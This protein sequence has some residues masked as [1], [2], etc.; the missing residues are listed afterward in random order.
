[1]EIDTSGPQSRPER[2]Y[3]TLLL[4]ETLERAGNRFILFRAFPLS[5]GN[6]C[7]EC[8]LVVYIGN[9]VTNLVLNPGFY[10]LITLER[11]EPMGSPLS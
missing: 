5:T 4:A 6:R 11:A 10:Q 9:G 1:M 3:I 2:S 7:E 8:T